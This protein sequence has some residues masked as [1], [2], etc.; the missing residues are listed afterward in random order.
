MKR[1]M[2]TMA[3]VMLALFSVGSAQAQG[4]LRWGAMVGA[5]FSKFSTDVNAMKSEYMTAFHIGPMVEYELP[6][7]PLGVEAGLR[8]SQKG[9]DFT[10]DDIRQIL[11]SNYVEI[12]VNAKYYFGVFP[13]IR[14]FLMAGP[15]FNFLIN[16]SL[17]DAAGGFKLDDFEAQK[18]GLDLN[19]GLGVEIMRFFQVSAAYSA[20][21]TNDYKF[22]SIGGVA[23]D[24]IN[25]KNKGFAVTAR[26]LF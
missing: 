19:A 12:P 24:Y 9:N 25:A 17:E 13:G 18:F 6:I 22:T 10:K 3:V 5:N 15:S 14:V 23:K 11:K 2:T 8:F 20:S 21:M 16:T 1:L 7:I 26:I 4:G